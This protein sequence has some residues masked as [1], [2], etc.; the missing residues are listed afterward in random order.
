M[1]RGVTTSVGRWGRARH[2][3]IALAIP[4]ALYLAAIAAMLAPKVAF[5]AGCV[6]R[7]RGTGR[8]LSGSR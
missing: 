3:V 1:P 7:S 2:V 8:G 4:P 5:L 6:I